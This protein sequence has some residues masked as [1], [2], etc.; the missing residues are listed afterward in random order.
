MVSYEGWGCKRTALRCVW[1]GC[2]GGDPHASLTSLL[3]GSSWHAPFTCISKASFSC[4][5]SFLE[6]VSFR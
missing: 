1:E 2:R 6:I 4:C 3:A 5:S